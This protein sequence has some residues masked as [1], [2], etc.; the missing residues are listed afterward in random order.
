MSAVIYEAKPPR[1][2]LQRVASAISP[3]GVDWAG[4]Q[5]GYGEFTG[6]DYA[7]ALVLAANGNKLS[8]V[9]FWARWMQDR[10]AMI[11]L[12]VM[13]YPVGRENAPHDAASTLSA[14]AAAEYCHGR[15]TPEEMRE[16]LRRPVFRR[17]R[18]P[19]LR[20]PLKR[21]GT[22]LKSFIRAW[23]QS[24]ELSDRQLAKTLNVSRTHTVPEI[25]SLQS[26]YRKAYDDMVHAAYRAESR[27]GAGLRAILA[28]E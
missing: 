9:A 23:R 24:Y 19:D 10:Q 3:S 16:K 17:V 26:R 13:L 6:N 7:L 28:P 1:E 14:V 8:L 2:L 27:L 5:R 11:D 4:S 20:I 22:D 25:R 15:M 12:A 21:T 18:N